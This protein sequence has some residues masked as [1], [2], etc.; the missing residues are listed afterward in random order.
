MAVCSSK[1]RTTAPGKAARFTRSTAMSF[2]GSEART[3]AETFRSASNCTARYSES[4]T[5]WRLVQII[6]AESAKKPVPCPNSLHT[7]TTL[8][9]KRW[10]CS[11][12][13]QPR[14]PSWARPRPLWRCQCL[15]PNGTPA[16]PPPNRGPRIF[17]PLEFDGLRRR[18]VIPSARELAL[19]LDRQIL[20]SGSE[21]RLDSLQIHH[22]LWDRLGIQILVHQ[23]CAIFHRNEVFL[24]P[25][26]RRAKQNCY[27]NNAL[28][29]GKSSNTR[30]A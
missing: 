5:T 28:F 3:H 22:Q 15:S 1:G 23:D 7:V 14:L 19:Q 10:N 25:H 20:L 2:C 6:P 4:A 27:S 30:V 8:F 9:F 16:A 12:D 13:C 21:V 18:Q 11:Q 26:A 17:L 29:H 24:S